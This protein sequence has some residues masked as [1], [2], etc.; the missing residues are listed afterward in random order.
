E[1]QAWAGSLPAC[2]RI[3]QR[4]W[5]TAIVNRAGVDDPNFVA[6]PKCRAVAGELFRVIAVGDGQHLVRVSRVSSLKARAGPGHVLHDHVCPLHH[7]CFPILLPPAMHLLTSLRSVGA[8]PRVT[9][10]GQPGNAEPS[11]EVQAQE[12][13]AVRRTGSEYGVR[14]PMP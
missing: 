7:G 5:I 14:A 12:V 8:Y 10:V 11:S 2:Q 13:H 1:A 6:V 4:A 9:E 3:E